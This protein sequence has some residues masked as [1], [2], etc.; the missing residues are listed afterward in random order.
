MASCRA[1]ALPIP[2]VGR[3]LRDLLWLSGEYY[4][5]LSSS[6]LIIPAKAAQVASSRACG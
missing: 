4:F 6:C 2:C 5:P 1:V 3:N